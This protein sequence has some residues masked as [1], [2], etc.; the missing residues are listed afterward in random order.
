MPHRDTASGDGRDRKTHESMV[1]LAH[2]GARLTAPENTIVAFRAA[3][4]AGADG[5]ELD[6]RRTADGALVCLH[7]ADVRR[8]TNGSGPV[9][10]QTLSQIQALDAAATFRSGRSTPFAGRGI[11]I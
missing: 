8:T 1:V 10:R 6:I 5:I 3:I 4:D 11:A 7:D 2:R 9:A